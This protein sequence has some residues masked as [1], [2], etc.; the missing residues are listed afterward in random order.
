M[1]RD[2]ARPRE[3]STPDEELVRPLD[4]P[5]KTDDHPVNDDLE[6]EDPEDAEA[7]QASDL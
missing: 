3:I 7:E 1:K 6:D 4:S 5:S 2:D